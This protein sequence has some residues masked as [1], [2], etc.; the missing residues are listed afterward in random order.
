MSGAGRIRPDAKFRLRKG[1]LLQMLVLL[2]L[3][4]L[5]MLMLLMLESRTGKR[6]DT[7]NVAGDWFPN[8]RE[9]HG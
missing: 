5:L 7:V 1:L 6:L 2:M 3:L 9:H 8:D 4:L